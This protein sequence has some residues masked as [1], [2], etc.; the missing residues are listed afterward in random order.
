M[1]ARAVIKR[2]GKFFS[3]DRAQVRRRLRETGLA[4]TKAGARAL[5]SLGRDH[6]KAAIEYKKLK[7][8]SLI[9]AGNLRRRERVLKEYLQENNVSSSDRAKL[10]RQIAGVVVLAKAAETGAANFSGWKTTSREK[11]TL[12]RLAAQ[13]ARKR[14][15]S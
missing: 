7:V 4:K 2:T 10:E 13:K 3:A 15:K 9:T 1:K 6:H 8:D 14:Q 12:Y 11:A 5:G